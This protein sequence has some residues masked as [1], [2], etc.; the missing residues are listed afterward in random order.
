M[1]HLWSGDRSHKREAVKMVARIVKQPLTTSEQRWHEINLHLVH[2]PGFEMLLSDPRTTFQRHILVAGDLPSLI[3][4]LLY[5]P[6]INVKVVPSV[7]T[8][9]SRGWCVSTNTG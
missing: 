9:G 6:V 3:D 4:R 7:S 2:E 1:N 5:P 8:R